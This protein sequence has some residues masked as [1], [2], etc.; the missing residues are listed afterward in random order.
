[1][2]SSV[3]FKESLQKILLQTNDAQGHVT[4][5]RPITAKDL[6]LKSDKICWFY[7]YFARPTCGIRGVVF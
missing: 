2:F 6:D 4:Q 3:I 7:A 1:M 5:M